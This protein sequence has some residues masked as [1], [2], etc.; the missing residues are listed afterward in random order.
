MYRLYIKT[1][2]DSDWTYYGMVT[3]GRLGSELVRLNQTFYAAKCEP[4]DIN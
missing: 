3:A 2:S 1:Y 4:E